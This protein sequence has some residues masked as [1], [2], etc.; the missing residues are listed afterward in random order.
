M[1]ILHSLSGR[2][3]MK[4]SEL[5]TEPKSDH[6]IL[7]I[8]DDEGMSYT[9][10]RMVEEAGYL[11]DTAFRLETGLKKALTGNYDV[12]FLDVRLPDGNGLEII[13]KIRSI[14]FAPEIIIITAYGEQGGADLALK[15]GAWDYLQKPADIRT[16]ELSLIR[17][18]E[19]RSQKKVL[20]TPIDIDRKGIIGTSPGLLMCIT[21]MGHAAKTNANVLIYGET[22]TGKELFARAIHLN[23]SRKSKPFIVVDCT[24]LPNTLAESILFGHSKGS[25]TGA[26]KTHEG[27]IEQADQGTLFLDEIGELPLSIQKKLLRVLQEKRFRPVGSEKEI[28][29][30]FRLVSATN[31][32][33]D[34]RVASKKFREDLLFRLRTFIIEIPPIRNRKRDIKELAEHYVEYFCLKYEF[35]TK[36]ISEDF[37]EVIQKYVWPGNIREFISSIES[38]VA[39]DPFSKLLFSKHLPNYIRIKALQSSQNGFLAANQCSITS[40]EPV[41]TLKDFRQNILAEAEKKYLEDLMSSTKWKIKMACSISGLKRARLYQLLKTYNLS[42]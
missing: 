25:F 21:L 7:I 24:S 26:D 15:S 40:T 3:W 9:I 5:D 33:L 39:I 31:R 19:Y 27:L 20:S 42:K 22:G 14:A 16:M 29:S 18:L 10:A 4:K 36:K 6:Q 37:F 17:A 8:D 12:V 41:Q 13:P 2:C 38:A 30:D 32:D 1:Q 35:E 23:S 28:K 34:E 11:A